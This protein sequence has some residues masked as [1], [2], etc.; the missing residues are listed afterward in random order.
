MSKQKEENRERTAATAIRMFTSNKKEASGRCISFYACRVF[1]TFYSLNCP[2][3]TLRFMLG[4]CC[5]SKPFS[6]SPVSIYAKAL[7]FSWW[8]TKE[9]LFRFL[10]PAFSHCQMCIFTRNTTKHVYRTTQHST[11][12]IHLWQ[13]RKFVDAL[14]F[15]F[16]FSSYIKEFV[17]GVRFK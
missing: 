3:I 5:F 9:R 1:I 12:H 11:A 2:Q 8:H 4:S 15:L 6:N 7:H 14:S 13:K 10:L 16:H 17:H